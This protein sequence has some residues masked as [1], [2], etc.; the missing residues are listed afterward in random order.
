M[1][2]S[3]VLAGKPVTEEQLF[4]LKLQITTM[5]EV[6]E[7]LGNPNIIWENVRVFVYSWDM[8]QGILFWAAVRRGVRAFILTNY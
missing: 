6:I 7:H 8:R 1:E 5:Q 4:F 3:K 2:E